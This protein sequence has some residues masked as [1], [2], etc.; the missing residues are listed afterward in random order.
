M[1]E[2][3]EIKCDRLFLYWYTTDSHRTRYIRTIKIMSRD[4][5]KNLD[6]TS[7]RNKHTTDSENLRGGT[8]LTG[9]SATKI[10]ILRQLVKNKREREQKK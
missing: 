1:V 10:K 6:R 5:K 2:S 9:L 3:R 7:S 8:A 4:T